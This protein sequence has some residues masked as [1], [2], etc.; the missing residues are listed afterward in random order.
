MKKSVIQVILIEADQEQVMLK[1]PFLDV[2]V[3]M[4]RNFFQRRLRNGYYKI[5]NKSRRFDKQFAPY[6]AN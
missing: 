6:Y 2:P 1:L 4:N 3:Q 5:L